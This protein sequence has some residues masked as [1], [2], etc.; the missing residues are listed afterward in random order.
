M[1]DKK[2]QGKKIT[3]LTAYDFFMAKLVDGAGVDAI[4]VGDSLGMVVLGYETTTS[5]TMDDMIR[6]ASAVRRG[7]VSAL[8]IGDMPY[9][10]YSD[11]V[12]AVKNAKRFAEES[13]CDAVKLEGEC[14]EAIKAILDVGIPVLGHLGLTPQTAQE[15]K[16]QGKEIA[17]AEK[18]IGASEELERVGCFAV[19]LECIPFEL[20][21]LVSSRLK[22]P[23]IGIGAGVDCD[24]QVLVIND[25]LGLFDRFKPKFVKK[26]ADLGIVAQEAIKRYKDAVE[27][28]EFPGPE[29]SYAMNK[30]NL[31]KVKYSLEKS[32]NGTAS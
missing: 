22:I 5:V 32:I 21:R 19:V 28:R 30:D 9:N 11:P 10:S 13:K 20:A 6:H 17:D 14:Y 25:L 7:A 16:V 27:K 31:Q 3:M 26:F 15:F 24:G 18:I 4:L 29:N 8:V 1:L 2:R 23:T 12:I